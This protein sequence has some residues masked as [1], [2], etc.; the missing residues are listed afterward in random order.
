MADYNGAIV[1]FNNAISL[2]PNDGDLYY[3]RGTAKLA[4][5]NYADAVD[6]LTKAV[7]LNPED[8][9][10]FHQRGY[11]Y[12]LWGKSTN[13]DFYFIKAQLDFNK[14]LNMN[15]DNTEAHLYRGMVFCER[16]KKEK[17]L[18]E[19]EYAMNTAHSS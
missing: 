7:E 17:G 8:E 15:P 12:A 11:A 13:T 18:P 19:I 6:D 16:G 10:S 14:V 5:Q 3:G 4:M 9:E 2:S 1:D